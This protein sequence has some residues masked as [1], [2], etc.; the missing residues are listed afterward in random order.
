MLETTALAGDASTFGHTLPYANGLGTMSSA[1]DALAKVAIVL[2]WVLTPDRLPRPPTPA[3]TPESGPDARA[4]PLPGLDPAAPI[5]VSS[6]DP[7]M[8]TSVHDHERLLKVK[9]LRA[10]PGPANTPYLSV[11]GL[12]PKV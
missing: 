5:H 12:D 10:P 2:W 3:P 4:T 11:T 7:I 9:R 6:D 8:C 1:S